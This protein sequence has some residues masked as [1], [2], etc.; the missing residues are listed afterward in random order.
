MSNEVVGKRYATALFQLGQEHSK[1]E[2]LEE[3]LRTIREVFRSNNQLMDFL[4]HPRIEQNKKKQLLHEAFQGYSTEVTHTLD[5]LMDRHREAVIL[6][7]VDEFIKLNNDA[8][9]IAEAEVYSVR[10]LSQ[11]E[12]QSIQDVFTKKLN[13][14]TLRIHNI[15]DPSILGGLKLKI[16][17]RIYDGSVSGK[18]ERM[19]RKLVSAN[20]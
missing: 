13:K 2:K 11:D 10:T 20:K 1:L 5:L 6:T 4:K 17:N 16:G 14:N 15:V 12:E 19:E 18:L 9:G 3:E 8:R 7:M